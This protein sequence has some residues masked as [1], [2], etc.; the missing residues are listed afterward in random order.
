[1]MNMETKKL[2]LVLASLLVS[3]S[4]SAQK[5]TDDELDVA[6]RQAFKMSDLQWNNLNGDVLS[7][8]TVSLGFKK[9]YGEWVLG[10]AVNSHDGE[11]Y[12]IYGASG[13]YLLK[14]IW[15]DN[16]PMKAFIYNYEGGSK[17]SS[18][19]TYAFRYNY[20]DYK[21]KGQISESDAIWISEIIDY[22][23]LSRKNGPDVRLSHSIYE[24]D[25]NGRLK[26]IITRPD[27]DPQAGGARDIFR[28]ASDGSYTMTRYKED[29]REDMTF[30]VSADGRKEI[31]KSDYIVAYIERD[32]D[33]RMIDVGGGG[34]GSN[35]YATQRNH[36]VY[37][38]HG[39]LLLVTADAKLIDRD[40]DLPWLEQQTDLGEFTYFEYE[41]DSKGNWI[42]R[43]TYKHFSMNR[44]IDLKKWEERTIVYSGDA[45]ISGDEYMAACN[46]EIDDYLAHKEEAAS[47]AA[48]KAAADEL[49]KSQHP[50]VTYDGNLAE[51]ILQ[52]VLP[53][54]PRVSA[55]KALNGA[56]GTVSIKLTIN[57]NGYLS[58]QA[59]EN[60]SNRWERAQ[61]LVHEAIKAAEDLSGCPKWTPGYEGVSYYIDFHYYPGGRVTI[62]HATYV[63]D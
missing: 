44:D 28:N 25:G 14:M 6:V 22:Q 52:A 63:R 59:V 49:L 30:Q 29:G 5:Y 34:G 32:K 48:A 11:E 10:G 27:N 23:L 51:D 40:K 56:E 15:G 36:Y 16:S 8:R 43:K 21:P 33:G 50:V 12:V 7:T 62:D 58:A 38:E 42:T 9:A 18:I 60:Y 31:R 13:N 57:C 19:D 55:L 61:L 45:G 53:K 54:L 1:M 20:V 2:L 46:K 35:G 41:Y 3:L 37:N 47:K 24:Y 17:L 26:T 39:D 4:V